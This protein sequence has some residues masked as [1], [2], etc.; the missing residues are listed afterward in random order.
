M[1]WLIFFIA[2]IVLLIIW[3]TKM[4]IKENYYKKRERLLVELQIQLI[5]Y[6]LQ[7]YEEEI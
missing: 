6:Q 1:I 2:S 7:E 4:A 3:I 5:Q